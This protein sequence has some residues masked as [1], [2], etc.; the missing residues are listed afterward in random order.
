MRV[1]DE[2]EKR[3]ELGELTKNGFLKLLFLG[4]EGHRREA[5]YF[6]LFRHFSPVVIKFVNQNFVDPGSSPKDLWRVAYSY[7]MDNHEQDMR[8]VYSDFLH[9]IIDRLAQDEVLYD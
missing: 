8:I 5:H 2:L 4:S 3:I 1:I 7:A 6:R 9:N